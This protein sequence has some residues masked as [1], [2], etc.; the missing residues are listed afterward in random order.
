MTNVNPALQALA[1][2]VLWSS[3]DDEGEPLDRFYTIKNFDADS[4]NKLYADYQLFLEEVEAK[5]SQKIGDAWSC[6]DDFYNVAQ[7]AE[8]QTEHDYVLTRGR[9]GSGFSDGDWDDSVAEIL[10][11]AAQKQSE[12]HVIADDGRL[13]IC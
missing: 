13:Y 3:C 4:L 1:E 9:Q 5:I 2:T 11:A 12:F 8:N 10:T 6:I 7:P